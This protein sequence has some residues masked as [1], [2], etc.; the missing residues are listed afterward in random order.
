MKADIIACYPKSI[1]GKLISYITNYEI[2]HVAIMINNNLIAESDWFGVRVRKI[3]DMKRDYKI[4]RY[5]GLTDFQKDK[6]IYFI[7]NRVNMKYDYKLLL[8]LGLKK[9]LKIDIKKWNNK[10]KYICTELIYIAYKSVGINLSDDT[11]KLYPENIL[12]NKK[13]KEVHKLVDTLEGWDLT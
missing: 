11:Y 6:I 7:L 12:K 1:I 10:D 5:D 8:G 9:V 4:L 3:E 2:S 13:L